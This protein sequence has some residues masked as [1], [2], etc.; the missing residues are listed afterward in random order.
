MRVRDGSLAVSART[1][2]EWERLCR[3]RG[4]EALLAD[5][6]YRTLTDRLAHHS[7]LVEHLARLFHTH[8]A[9][10]WMQVLTPA[11]VP[12]GRFHAYDEM[13]LRPQVRISSLMA[14]VPTPH[15]GTGHAA[16]LPWSYSLT[17]GVL[18]SSPL[19][20]SAIEDVGRA[21]LFCQKH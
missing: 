8:P 11:G 21:G 6:R 5:P 12:C 2:A 20:G 18:R 14:E 1:Q 7:T 3:A 4:Q 15:W 10:W 16:G 9:S 19:L 17:P 13:C